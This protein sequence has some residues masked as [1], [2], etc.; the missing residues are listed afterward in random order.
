[1]SFCL[2]TSKV[3]EF[4][5]KLTTGEFDPVKLSEM[6]SEG[7]RALF[8]KI[9][10][11][12]DAKNVNAL[13]ESKL[14]LKDQQQGMIN[15][16]KKV[17]GI[18]PDVKRDMLS[19]IEKM[20][21]I[22]NPETEKVFLEDLASHRLGVTV[23]LGEAKSISKLAKSVSDN[24]AK[25]DPASPIQ[26]PDR[27]AYGRALVDFG[28]YVSGLK[29]E[30][31]KTT[32]ADVKNAPI[33]TLVKATSD[34]AGL[35]KSLKATLDNSV[36]GRQGLKVLFTHPGVWLKNSLNTFADIVKTFGGKDVMRE[37]SADVLSRPN[38]LNGLYQREKLALGVIEE[39]YPTN[40]P[41]KIPGLGR[42]FKAS[43]TAFTAFQYR[44]R[45]DVFDKYMQIAEKSG[46]DDIAGIGKIAN[47]LTGR[48]TFGQRGES[49][50]TMTNNVFFS[51]RFLKSNIDLLT[52]HFS[53]SGIGSF[54]RK[55]A[56]INTVKVIGG[57]AAIL[58]IADQVIPGSVEKDPRS[59]DFGKIRIGDTRF[60]VTGGMSSLATLAARL[61]SSSSK[62]STT[63]KV[64]KLNTGKFG[65]MTRT[66]VILNFFTNKLSPAGSLVKDIL[67]GEDFQ[68]N[69]ITAIG[70][71]NNLLTPMPITTFMELRDNPNS[72]NIVLAMLA[73]M[74][75]ISTNTYSKNKK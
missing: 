41:E 10:G 38:S 8:S 55:Q 61:I 7:R 24:K 9:V 58:A 25:I 32:L 40:F 67:N 68:H 18:K 15:W 23:S 20:E 35:A 57:I 71:L 29:N 11:E 73:D 48:G 74:L 19:K 46:A 22:L 3:N 42:V 16:A 34:L 56:A 52:M 63:G 50:A 72:A 17:T 37:V 66:D 33:K 26:S 12:S 70:E 45:A 28:D 30:A 4:I 39:A 6:T 5:K 49:M 31:K 75:G 59:A 62:S 64:S 21:E 53:D 2:T 69:K 43:E 27:M 13:F 51:P 65:S 60:D 14:L 54:A 44:T 1:M 36:I 47:S